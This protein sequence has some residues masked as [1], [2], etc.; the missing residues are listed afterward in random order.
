MAG[1]FQCSCIKPDEWVKGKVVGLGSFGTVYL[2][3]NKATGALFVVKSAESGAGLEALENESNILESL[4]SP[5]IVRCL[6]R[7]SSKGSNGEQKLNIFMEYMAGGSLSDV[8]EKFGGALDEE[9]IRVYARE[10]LNGLKYLH[11][12]GI[13]HCDIKCKNVLLGSSG[14]VKLADFGCAKRLTDLKNNGNAA[15]SWQSIGGTPLWMAPEVL[16]NERLDFAA[17]IWSLG[18]T[19][20]E[21]ATG[22]APWGSEVSNQMAAVL[23]IACSNETPPFPTHFSKEGVDFLA[24]CLER[25]PDKRWTSE[26]LLKHPF[27]SGRLVRNSCK[28]CMCSPAST[29]DVGIN[30]EDSDS[31]SVESEG[32]Y[33]G[34]YPSRNPFSSRH[35]I[36]RKRKVR[37]QESENHIWS[38]GDWITVRSG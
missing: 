37:R 11:E 13:V 14:N 2:A 24:R 3:M 20:V 27:I 25:N 12:K 35:S 21:L 34:D 15:H 17:D 23:K 9:V 28:E 7:D 16:R 19:V 10:M 36:E 29:L 8:A 26:D 18:C 32:P 22:R 38:S 31:D 30:E 6:G 5:Y 1:I 33:E 4:D